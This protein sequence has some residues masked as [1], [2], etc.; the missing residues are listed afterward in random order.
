VACTIRVKDQQLPHL[1][2]MVPINLVGSEALISREW[3]ITIKINLEAVHM[4]HMLKSKALPLV[5]PRRKMSRNRLLW[6]I[7]QILAVI[8]TLIVMI[9]KFKR[10]RKRRQPKRQKQQKL[11][12]KLKKQNMKSKQL[13]NH[14]AAD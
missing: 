13:H 6:K 14:R 10:R 9:L 5:Q 8:Q 1:E 12:R 4:I 2:I 3:D 11:P 7:L